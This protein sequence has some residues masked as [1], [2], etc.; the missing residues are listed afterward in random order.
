MHVQL[1]SQDPR[2]GEAQEETAAGEGVLSVGVLF[3]CLLVT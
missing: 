3:R 2:S 1:W